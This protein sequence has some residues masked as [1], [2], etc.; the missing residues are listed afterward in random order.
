MRVEAP[1]HLSFAP[2]QW[3]GE[4]EADGDDGQLV[5]R[6]KFKSHVSA[7]N[8]TVREQWGREG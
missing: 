2:P 4:A 5:M 7:Q 6:L 3:A 8:L 1:T